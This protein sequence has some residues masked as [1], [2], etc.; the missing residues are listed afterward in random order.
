MENDKKPIKVPTIVLSVL[1][2][3][4]SNWK[5]FTMFLDQLKSPTFNLASR[6]TNIN[7]TKFG[8]SR[9]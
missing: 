9:Q 6:V 7:G 4:R 1:K 2:S 5:T 3:P 8:E